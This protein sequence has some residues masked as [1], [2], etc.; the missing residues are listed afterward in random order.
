MTV[1]LCVEPAHR[2]LKK[3]HECGI[4]TG[5]A[6]EVDGELFLFSTGLWTQQGLI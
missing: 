4:E 3:V 6:V 5:L 2:L 1:V